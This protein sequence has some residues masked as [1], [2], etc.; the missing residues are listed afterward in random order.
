M[1]TTAG[2]PAAVR[3]LVSG[4]VQGVYYRASTVA[5]AVQLGLRGWARNLHDGR[6]EVVA[7]GTPEAIVELTTWLWNG[8]PSARVES[9]D[10]EAWPEPVPEGFAVR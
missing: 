1:T 2:S 7:A 6:V 10:F 3:C 9:V 4:R 8:P 5:V